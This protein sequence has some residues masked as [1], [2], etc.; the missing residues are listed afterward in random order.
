MEHG[1]DRKQLSMEYCENCQSVHFRTTNVLLNFN[2]R[3][4]TEL[5][6]AVN[7]IYFNDTG[8]GMEELSTEHGEVIND[9][10]LMSEVIV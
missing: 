7:E 10:V 6:K 5:V 4:F 1:N 9:D 3:E 2:K 8:W